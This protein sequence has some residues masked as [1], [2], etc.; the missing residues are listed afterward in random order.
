MID[1]PE[2]ILSIVYFLTLFYTIFLLVAFLED[3]PQK[4][5]KIVDFPNVSVVIP[6]YNESHSIKETMQSVIDLD[7]PKDKIELIVVNDGSKDDTKKIVENFICKNKER[8]I[9]LLNQ[10]N[11]GKYNA[12][13]FGLKIA[14]GEYFACLDADSI[15]EKSALKKMLPYFTSS[16]IA[17]V[18]PLM[19][20][21]NPKNIWQKIQHYEYVINMF[22]KKIMSNLN[23]VHVAP[24][25][26]SLYKTSIVIKEG[27]FR[28]GHNTEDLEITLR[29]QKKNYKIV[30][31]MNVEVFTLSPESF[32]TLYVQRNRWNM[33]SVLNAWDYRKM[34]FNKK[35]GDFGLFQMPFVFFAGFFSLIIISFTIMLN[36]LK[37][38]FEKIHQLSLVNYDVMTYIRNYHFEFNLLDF[39]YYKVVIFITVLTISLMVFIVSHKYCREKIVKHGILTLFTFMFFYYLLLGIIWLG[40][41]K[42]LLLRRRVKW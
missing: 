32:R 3:K 11:K 31:L 14:K 39:N 7:Y 17:V 19:K 5:K 28:K 6:A 8:K 24:G 18:L 34:I 36:I 21:R 20:I 22:Y 37:P 13:N 4:Q 38:L 12:L 33:G 40:I 25:P 2:L 26:F 1:I 23:C 29:L 35:Y 42:D 10:K 9:I 27:G 15:V 30:Q 16:K 41:F